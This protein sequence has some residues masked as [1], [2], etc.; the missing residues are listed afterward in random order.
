MLHYFVLQF[1]FIG[2]YYKILSATTISVRIHIFRQ[3]WLSCHISDRWMA[4]R[5]F[6]HHQTCLISL[7]S[8]ALEAS[9]PSSCLEL[10]RNL[11]PLC[12]VR[13]V[14]PSILCAMRPF[15]INIARYSFNCAYERNA[16]YII[17]VLV[18]PPIAA[19]KISEVT[20][21]L[22]LYFI[23]IN[24]WWATRLYMQAR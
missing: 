22:P 13:Y 8:G 5:G 12:V 19:S 11:R 9:S 20:S 16:L 4:A 14:S 3:T 24:L 21:V 23:L 2:L 6:L 17:L 7:F 18:A 15:W 1:L 10:S